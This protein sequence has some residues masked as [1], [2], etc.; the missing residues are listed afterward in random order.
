MA[1]PDIVREYGSAFRG[2]WSSYSIDGRS[3][4]MEMGDLATWIEDPD[5]YPG[6]TEARNRFGICPF[7]EGHWTCHCDESCGSGDE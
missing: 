6:D 7:G 1:L 2:D 3:V 4:Q 5:T